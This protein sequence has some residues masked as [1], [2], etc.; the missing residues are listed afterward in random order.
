M[1]WFTIRKLN[2]I[3]ML[4]HIYAVSLKSCL[5]HMLR[6]WL[7]LLN[8]HLNGLMLIFI[9]WVNVCPDF[10]L[11]PF[12]C[13]AII[14]LIIWLLLFYANFIKQN[15]KLRTLTLLLNIYCLIL[16]MDTCMSLIIYIAIYVYV[17]KLMSNMAIICIWHTASDKTLSTKILQMYLFIA[18][19]S[20]LGNLWPC[21]TR[22]TLG[23]S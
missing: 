23:S 18:C 2:N 19:G 3:C 8:W 7:K 13:Q 22:A 15:I 4:K 1:P 5:Q 6:W 12:W 10:D 11:L 21:Y 17:Y 9:A 16:S 14:W 20:S